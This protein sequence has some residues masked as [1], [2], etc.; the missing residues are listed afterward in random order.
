[1]QTIS[2]RDLIPENILVCFYGNNRLTIVENSRRSQVFGR[3]GRI[4]LFLRSSMTI[5]D[6]RWM[7]VGGEGFPLRER[8]EIGQGKEP[9]WVT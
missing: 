5:R 3:D 6:N 7:K 9:K 2:E 1:M 8:A 4:P